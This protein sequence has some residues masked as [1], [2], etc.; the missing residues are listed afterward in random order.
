M[1]S[2]WPGTVPVSSALRVP[3]GPRHCT[4]PFSNERSKSPAAKV[5]DGGGGDVL[6]TVTVTG[7]EMVTLPAASRATAV[8]VCDPSLVVVVSHGTEYGASVSS[9]PRSA[10][11]S[12]NWT[13]ATPTSS[14]AVATTSMVRLTVAPDDGDAM[15]TDGGLVSAGGPVETVT[16]T[17]AEVNIAAPSTRSEEHTSELQSRVDLVC[18]LL[19]AKKKRRPTGRLLHMSPRP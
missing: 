1:P 19:L 7:S 13:P 6:E 8:R 18:R 11:S 5:S 12:L 9:A 4:V 15:V 16:L 10:S 3:S 14:E 2:V 17:G